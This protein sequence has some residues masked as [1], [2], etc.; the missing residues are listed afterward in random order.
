MVGVS[1]AVR[2][3]LASNVS[4][5]IASCELFRFVFMFVFVISFGLTVVVLLRPA[6][7]F[8][9]GVFS[10]ERIQFGENRLGAGHADDFCAD[11]A[12][13][14]KNQHGDGL[15]PV[16]GPQV[17]IVIHVHFE[18][19]C[20][21]VAGLSDFIQNRLNELAWFAPTCQ[22]ADQHRLRATQ[23]FRL[24]LRLIDFFGLLCIHFNFFVVLLLVYQSA[25]QVCA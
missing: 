17:G 6:G 15:N 25:C 13:D 12:V 22:K 20:V 4:V 9:G 10:R 3:S 11:R 14:E 19:V 1:T 21:A 23:N 16:D 18:N 5:A 8:R 7:F 24:K 2:L